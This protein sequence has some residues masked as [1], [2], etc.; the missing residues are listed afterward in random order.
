MLCLPSIVASPHMLSLVSPLFPCSP[1]LLLY[2][3]LIRL[4]RLCNPMHHLLLLLPRSPN[5]GCI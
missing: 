1:L 5:P 4:P 3:P 2:L